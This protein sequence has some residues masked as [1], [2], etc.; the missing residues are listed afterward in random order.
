[1]FATLVAAAG[2]AAIMLAATHISAAADNLI[3]IRSPSFVG[4][5]SG[6]GV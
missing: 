1:V 4:V 3:F 2:A 5:G 6:S